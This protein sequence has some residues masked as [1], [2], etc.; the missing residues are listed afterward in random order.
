MKKN[1]VVGFEFF[2]GDV[3]SWVG[4]SFFGWGYWALG[5]NRKREVVLLKFLVETKLGVYGACD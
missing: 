1:Q 3:I 5:P 4:L 2:V